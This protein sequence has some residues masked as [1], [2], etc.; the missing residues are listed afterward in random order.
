[1]V[2]EL[3]R[4]LFHNLRERVEDLFEVQIACDKLKSLKYQLLLGFT[5]SDDLHVMANLLSLLERKH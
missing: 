1:M 3:L 5:K 2:L 4:E